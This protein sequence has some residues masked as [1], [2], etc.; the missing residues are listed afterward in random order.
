MIHLSMGAYVTGNHGAT[1]QNLKISGKLLYWL[2]RSSFRARDYLKYHFLFKKSKSVS[3]KI[4][5]DKR[6][7]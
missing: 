4:I 2:W 3:G 1:H 6:F 5:L 7:F